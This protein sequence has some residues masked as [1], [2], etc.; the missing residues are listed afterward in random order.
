MRAIGESRDDKWQ[1]CGCRARSRP[2]KVPPCLS[3]RHQMVVERTHVFDLIHTHNTQTRHSTAVPR[4][5][6][7]LW[8]QLHNCH[9]FA[10]QVRLRTRLHQCVIHAWQWPGLAGRNHSHA[11]NQTHTVTICCRNVHAATRTIARL[12][13]SHQHNS[14]AA[15][16]AHSKSSA[17]ASRSHYKS[18]YI[19]TTC[20]L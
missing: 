8:P 19:P 12:P 17:S 7:R 2:S 4:P 14:T 6:P 20:S 18:V 3:V 16:T 15:Y 9:H 11:H 10:C 5:V 13:A 1:S